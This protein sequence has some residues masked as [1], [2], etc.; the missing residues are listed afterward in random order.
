MRTSGG[1]NGETR[2]YHIRLVSM[3]TESAAWETLIHCAV[4]SLRAD[5]TVHVVSE[6]FQG[7]VIWLLVATIA[8][9]N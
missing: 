6:Q 5:F 1:G 7:K 8:L 3:P 9:S 4:V 2:A